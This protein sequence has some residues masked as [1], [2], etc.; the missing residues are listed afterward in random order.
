MVIKLI[1]A[2]V[3][4][5]ILNNSPVSSFMLSK[6]DYA[7]L[8]L[9][10]CFRQNVV[11]NADLVFGQDE[12]IGLSMENLISLI[13]RLELKYPQHSPANILGILLKR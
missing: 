10:K 11:N 7:N 1:T 9:P 13:E 8:V 6:D 4:L 5:A 3:L 2:L 12:P